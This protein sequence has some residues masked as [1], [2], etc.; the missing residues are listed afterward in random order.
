VLLLVL[1]QIDPRCP[2]LRATVGE[3]S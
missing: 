3:V 2:I 1:S